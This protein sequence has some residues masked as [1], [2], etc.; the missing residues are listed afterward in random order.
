[1]NA[2]QAGGEPASGRESMACPRPVSAADGFPG[3]HTAFGEGTQNALSCGPAG[4]PAVTTRIL[5]QATVF[6]TLAFRCRAWGVQKFRVIQQSGIHLH[7]NANEMSAAV[8][9]GT[10]R[11]ALEVNNIRRIVLGLGS[12]SSVKGCNLAEYLSRYVVHSLCI[13]YSLC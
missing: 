10:F 5:H 3:S 8:A 4:W 7:A 2:R 11:T 1:M 13:A 6:S 9:L 12:S